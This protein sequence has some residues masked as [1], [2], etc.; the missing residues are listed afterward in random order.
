MVH[1][2]YLVNIITNDAK[3]SKDLDNRLKDGRCTHAKSS[4]FERL[5]KSMTANRSAL[6]QRFRDTAVIVPT[7]V[8]GIVT[9]DLYRKQIRLLE[10]FHPHCL[11]SIS[12]IQ[13]QDR[14]SNEEVLKKAS[15]PSK[16]H[17]ASKAAALG[18]P[19]LKDGRRTHAK[20]SL[21]QLA[22]RRK[23][24]P[25]RSRKALLKDQLKRQ[26]AQVGISHQSWQQK[27]SD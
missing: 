12:G 23:A 18:W 5:S 19:T 9:W 25:R 8:Y 3:V 4:S 6:P 10:R 22:P 26:L 11:L 13:W 24:S 14:V 1:F 17:P 27:A 2:T 15:L 16:V 21:L 20:S 7:L